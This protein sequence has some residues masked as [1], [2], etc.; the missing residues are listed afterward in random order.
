MSAEIMGELDFLLRSVFL[1]LMITFLYDVIRIFRRVL[2]HGSFLVS[3]E[4]LAFWI[5]CSV[6]IFRL[7]YHE[8]NGVFRWFVIMGAAAG[9]LFYKMTLSHFFVEYTAR[10]I[11]AV[12][13]VF[14]KIL[15]TLTKPARMAGSFLK[16][17]LTRAWKM[18]RIILCKQ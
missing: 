4:D 12:L 2:R 3:L 16:K 9:M 15:K 13:E 6:C 11:C 14:G 18:F 7:L 8:N 5:F 10:V 17:Q 1:G